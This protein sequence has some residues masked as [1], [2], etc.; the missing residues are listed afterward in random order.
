MKE[1]IKEAEQ[2]YFNE[3]VIANKGNSG[4]MWKTIRSALP[5]K[6]NQCLHYTKDTDALANDFKF[7]ISVGKD[8]AIKSAELVATH[9]L[10][11]SYPL[12]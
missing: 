3:Q 5:A 12:L 2:N 9:G 10:N 1:A 6:L 11:D 4:A 8:A 7:F